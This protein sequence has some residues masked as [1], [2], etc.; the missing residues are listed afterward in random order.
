MSGTQ[1]DKCDKCGATDSK[2]FWDFDDG[3]VLCDSCNKKYGNQWKKLN[4]KERDS[5]NLKSDKEELYGVEGWLA[6]FVFA[7]IVSSILNII[8]S[9]TEIASIGELGLNMSDVIW[10]TILVCIYWMGLIGLGIY[11]IYLILKL[12][13][14]AVMVAKFYLIIVFLSNVL[15]I[16]ISLIF[17]QPI[18]SDTGFMND[19]S[20]II[21]SVVF[22]IVWFLYL[23]YSQRIKNT[24]PKKKRETKTIDKLIFMIVLAII[25]IMNIFP[26][27]INDSDTNNTDAEQECVDYC[28]KFSQ[29]D[30]YY[31]GYDET[32]DMMLCECQ[33]GDE[34]ISSTKYPLID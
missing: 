12:K 2:T 16:I 29:V 11:A 32:S 28:S 18:S 20:M 10:I 30:S 23:T 9:I 27:L 24:Y 14:N 13:N 26:F 19:T 6:F 15:N 4:S 34:L 25:I 31:Y 17:S 5:K 1:K 21:R 8:S 33:S 22:S 3:S 7:L